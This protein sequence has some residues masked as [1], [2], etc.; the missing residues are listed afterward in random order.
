MRELRK[1]GWH[2]STLLRLRSDLNRQIHA[3]LAGGVRVWTTDLICSPRAGATQPDRAAIGEP[4]GKRQLSTSPTSRNT[5]V[6]HAPTCNRVRLSRS[7]TGRW[8]A[9]RTGPRRTAIYFIDEREREVHP[10]LVQ[11]IG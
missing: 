3:V 1:L 8:A 7:A 5:T 10:L 2:R 6:S 4:P 9:L 11:W